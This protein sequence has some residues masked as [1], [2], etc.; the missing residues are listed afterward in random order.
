MSECLVII[1]FAN[2]IIN[3]F[4]V[5]SG[6]PLWITFCMLGN[7]VRFSILS[8]DFS[9]KIDEYLQNVKL[10]RSISD[11]TCSRAW[12]RSKLFARLSADNEI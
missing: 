12:S 11:L 7:I 6:G 4:P 5:I 9:Y 1:S 3:Y 8:A 2:R 10:F